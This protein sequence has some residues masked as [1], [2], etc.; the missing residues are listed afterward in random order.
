MADVYNNVLTTSWV[1]GTTMGVFTNNKDYLIQNQGQSEI[2]VY[3]GSDTPDESTRD[4]V[5]IPMLMQAHLKKTSDEVYFRAKVGTA[6]IN[7]SEAE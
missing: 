5:I 4:G 3:V 1:S 7:I 6:R 2:Q